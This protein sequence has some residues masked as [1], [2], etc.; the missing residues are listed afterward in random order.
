MHVKIMSDSGVCLECSFSDFQHT[1]ESDIQNHVIFL[2]E[3]EAVLRLT[4]TTSYQSAI[5]SIHCESII[6]SLLQ[7]EIICP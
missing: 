7:T 3:Y 5:V 1:K 2:F 6:L 4:K